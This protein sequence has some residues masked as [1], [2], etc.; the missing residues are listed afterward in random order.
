M[1]GPRGGSRAGSR[2]RPQATRVAGVRRSSGGNPH[3]G[4]RRLRM[5]RLRLD[6]HEMPVRLAQ[7]AEQPSSQKAPGSPAD[8]GRT[9]SQRGGLMERP[10]P[11]IWPVGV[12][13]LAL[14]AAGMLLIWAL[15]S[16]PTD[17]YWRL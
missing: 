5:R 15:A 3:P 6:R 17:N 13:L 10:D 11:K 12:A 2:P 9:L 14:V 7:P 4:R 1:A 8:A 16:I